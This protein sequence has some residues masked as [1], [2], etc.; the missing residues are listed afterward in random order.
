MDKLEY[1]Q[2]DLVMTN[3]VPIG[4]DKDVVYRVTSSDPSKTLELNDGTVLKGVVRLE[5]IEGAELGDKG[6]LFGDCC[7]WVKDIVHI[8][9]T[10]E[11]L[12]KNGWKQN[13]GQY[14]FTYKPYAGDKVELIGFF[15]EMFKDVH[16]MLKHRYFQIT[17]EDKV[18]CGCFYV[19]QLQH[20]LFGLGINHKME[21]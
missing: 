5:N 19:H 21:V 9:L 4:T 20:H 7:A 1:I 15:I 16:D 3:G 2:G 17:H 8:P 14:S 18:I 12:K 6:Y 11:I 10:P 13:G